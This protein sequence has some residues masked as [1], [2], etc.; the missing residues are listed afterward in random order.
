MDHSESVKNSSEF[1]GLLSQPS[2]EVAE[3]RELKPPPEEGVV[4][5]VA[6]DPKPLGADADDPNPP[7]PPPRA[8]DD[9]GAFEREDGMYAIGAADDP[10]PLE[11]GAA[12]DPKGLD[13]D[14]KGL[15]EGDALKVAVEGVIAGAAPPPKPL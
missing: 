13:P 15:E 14:P 9:P 12:G 11:E 5:E 8:Q 10:K 4:N 7:P 6:P 3:I 2:S 1:S